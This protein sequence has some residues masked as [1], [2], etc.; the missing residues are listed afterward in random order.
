MPT[1]CPF[2]PLPEMLQKWP[3]PRNRCR[4]SPE[5]YIDKSGSNGGV[6]GV[7]EREPIDGAATQYETLYEPQPGDIIIN[8]IWARHGSVAVIQE[9]NGRLLCIGGIP[10]VRSPIFRQTLLLMVSLVYKA[11]A[12]AGSSATKNRAARV[13]R[14]GFVQR[15]SLEIKTSPPLIRRAAADCGAHRGTRRREIQ[16]VRELRQQAAGEAEALFTS[17]YRR[18]FEL[19]RVRRLASHFD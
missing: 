2:V 8:K 4:L 15:F 14:I 1:N 10:D 7:Y 11:Y 6:A 18:A 19:H 13:G 3:V 17:Y 12:I 16:E 5:L 9:L